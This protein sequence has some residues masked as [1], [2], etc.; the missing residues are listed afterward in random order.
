MFKLVYVYLNCFFGPNQ[1]SLKY[2]IQN[3]S[4]SIIY[5]RFLIEKYESKFGEGEGV[6]NMEQIEED[7][8]NNISHNINFILE[9]NC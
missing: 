8:F 7:L 6:L 1:E 9:L 4:C 2:M 3:I 5:Q